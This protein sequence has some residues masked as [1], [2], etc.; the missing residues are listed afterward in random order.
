[1]PRHTSKGTGQP[2]GG[3]R[4]D[5]RAP[6]C[7]LLRTILRRRRGAVPARREKLGASSFSERAT[8]APRLESPR[9]SCHDILGR[10]PGCAGATWRRER[11]ELPT[12]G[13]RVSG[14]LFARVKEDG[15]TL[16]VRT[17]RDTREALMEA[18]P[19]TFFVTPHYR[20]HDWMLIRLSSVKPEELRE[21]LIA[22]WKRRGSK[23]VLPGLDSR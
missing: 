20:G 13:F 17:D 7:G 19:S 15:V 12:S 1:M 23:K 6:S 11:T 3:R 9:A 4:R 5:R 2:R 16:V 22:A 21:Q 8:G 18:N 14:K 10:P